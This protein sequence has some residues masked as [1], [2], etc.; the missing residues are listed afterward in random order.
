[1]KHSDIRFDT[2]MMALLNHLIGRE[3]TKYKCDPFIF[4]PLVYGIAGVCTKD[5][6]IA[7]TNTIE[8]MDHYGQL[9]DVAVFRVSAMP[10]EK[11][12][13]MV[14]G[15]NM[16]EIHIQQKISEIQVVNENQRLFNNEVQT[17][18]V[19]IT[20]GVIFK[21]A[22]NLEIS[23]EKNVWFSEMITVERGYNLL[24]K[25]SPVSRFTENWEGN[26]RGECTREIITL[27]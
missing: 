10:E 26:Y 18:D 8:V 7:F 9:E 25:F 5:L 11:I 12:C 23:F 20:R 22:D 24:E 19:W 15:K 14:K 13:S 17:Y 2:S 21:L 3:L 1:M 4:S 27:H 16:Q 6:S